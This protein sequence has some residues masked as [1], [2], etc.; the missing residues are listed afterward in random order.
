L[1]GVDGI[2][3]SRP[4]PAEGTAASLFALLDRALDHLTA[5]EA[6]ARWFGPT[7]F[8]AYLRFKRVEA[9]KVASLSPTELCAH[10]AEIY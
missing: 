3:E 9:E 6:A 8:D 1:V 7:H 10:Y 4:V 5:S 2:R